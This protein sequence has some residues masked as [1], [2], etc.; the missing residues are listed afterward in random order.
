[1]EQIQAD[2]VAMGT[3]MDTRVD[4]LMEI[5][6]NLARQQ[7]EMRAMIVRPA[8]GL[9][10]GS[11]NP[12]AGPPRVVINNPNNIP[13]AQNTVE[14]LGGTRN[15]NVGLN[16]RNGQHANFSN[17]T[18]NQGILRN[19]AVGNPPPLTPAHQNTEQPT[20]LP[21]PIRIPV[22]PVEEDNWED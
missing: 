16:A 21:R 19:Q 13:E 7:E 3:R 12:N 10:N 9:N 22:R 1:M 6:Q 18:G 11:E 20:M 14:N 8:E 5:I 17:L 4:Q 15:M 2:V